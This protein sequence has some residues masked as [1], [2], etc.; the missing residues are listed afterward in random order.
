MKRVTINAI[1]DIGCL[2]TFIP[3]LIT[4]LVLYLVLPSG[5]GRGHNW[6]MYLG[7]TRSQ[8][9]TM[10]NYTSFAFVALLILHLLL[11]VKFF[12]HIG[13]NLKPDE[14]EPADC[15]T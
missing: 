11:H 9:V 4:G 13:R 6:S 10:H 5:G 8:W 1:I 14:K 7:I 15:L 2:I 12:R 3:S